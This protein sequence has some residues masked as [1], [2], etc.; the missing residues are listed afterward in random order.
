MKLQSTKAE[1]QDLHEVHA[2]ERE[3]LDRTFE[4]LNRELKLK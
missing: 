3:E 4:D 1:I 2:R